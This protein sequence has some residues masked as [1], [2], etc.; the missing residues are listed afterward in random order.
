[1]C[2]DILFPSELARTEVSVNFD[3]SHRRMFAF[4]GKPDIMFERRDVCL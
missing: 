1:M 2:E 3:A 4:G